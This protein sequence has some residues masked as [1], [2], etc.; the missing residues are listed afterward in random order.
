MFL[1]FVISSNFPKKSPKYHSH[2][3]VVECEI[4]FIIEFTCKYFIF[5]ELLLMSYNLLKIMRN[6]ESFKN[7]VVI[8]Q[9]KLK[10]FGPLTDGIFFESVVVILFPKHSLYMTV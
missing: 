1:Q 9:E 6:Y 7:S 4:Y 3:C 5:L 2:H 10:N 8:S